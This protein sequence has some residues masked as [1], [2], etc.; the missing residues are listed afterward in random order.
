MKSFE[1]R[2]FDDRKNERRRTRAF[3][4]TFFCK[5]KID[6]SLDLAQLKKQIYFQNAKN[7]CSIPR[8]CYERRVSIEITKITGLP[9]FGGWSKRK[10]RSK[11]GSFDRKLKF[12]SK[13][14]YF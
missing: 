4:I 6:F 14:R 3:Y 2:F 5:N 12:R 7:L 13:N 10:C 11:V 8:S 9:V 1:C